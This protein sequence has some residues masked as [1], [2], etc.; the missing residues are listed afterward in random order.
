MAA[1]VKGGVGF[2]IRRYLSFARKDVDINKSSKMDK[3]HFRKKNERS[4]K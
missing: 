4:E 3:K 2:K 1:K